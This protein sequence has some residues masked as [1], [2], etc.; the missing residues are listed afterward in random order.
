MRRCACLG[1]PDAEQ[2][3]H[4]ASSR[5]MPFRRWVS[6]PPAPPARQHRL[7]PLSK[8][9]RAPRPMPQPRRPSRAPCEPQRR[10]PPG[11]YLA[12]THR[13]RSKARDRCERRPH[14]SRA[15]GPGGLVERRE[16]TRIHRAPNLGIFRTH[17]IS[18]SGAPGFSGGLHAGDLRLGA[19]GT[20]H[21]QKPLQALSATRSQPWRSWSKGPM[22]SV[23]PGMGFS[24]GLS[25]PTGWA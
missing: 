14:R 6:R 11:M 4:A 12:G 21:L 25:I 5:L 20:L 1:A 8:G 2:A 7:P 22:R 9:A 15:N 3:C 16:N 24:Q 18:M 10:P 17:E 13:R 23:L 19:Q